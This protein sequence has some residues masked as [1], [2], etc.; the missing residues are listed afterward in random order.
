MSDT[1]PEFTSFGVML[2]HLRRRARLTQRELGIS[3]GYSEAHIARL[4]ADQRRPDVAAVTSRFVEAL[5]LNAEPALAEQFVSLAT[6]ARK[7]PAQSTP[8]DILSDAPPTNL[9]EQLTAFIG[10]EDEMAEARR[11]LR[12]TRLLT[13]TGMG[14]IGK[15]RLAAQVA[16]ELLT[17]YGDGAWIVS[18]VNTTDPAQVIT[19]V[20]ATMNLASSDLLE[21]LKGYLRNRKALLVLDNCEHVVAECA[22]VAVSLLQACP[23]LAVIVTSREALNVPGEVAW[24]LPPMTCDE[25]HSL[26]IERARAMRP[27]FEATP[28]IEPLLT[29]ICN[30]LEGIP[31]AIELAAS[32]LQ[33][34]SLQE[35]VD[36]LGDR[37]RLLAGGNR[38]AH[39]RHQSLRAL[40]D[41]SYNL[42]TPA[43][44]DLFKML[45]VFEHD[46][47]LEDVERIH[48]RKTPSGNIGGSDVLD[49]LTQLVKKSLVMIDDHA[50]PVRYHMFKAVR[51]YALERAQEAA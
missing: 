29:E 8:S 47:A 31:L 41:W 30:E 50:V 46:W 6:A 5:E 18:F 7:S 43:E 21:G 39:P 37:F 42:L 35:I 26:F 45:S 9:R 1:T 36:L 49:L 20:A 44:R 2:R 12:S 32:R 34:L 4:E 11:L 25:T 15:S 22:H 10:R 24:S 14:G 19:T 27:D 51:L 17:A 33:V 13:I 28:D 48:A 38:L 23:H 40:I 16:A 3:V